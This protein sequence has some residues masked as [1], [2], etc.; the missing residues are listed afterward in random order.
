MD[1][2]SSACELSDSAPSR[3]S[4]IAESMIQLVH[5]YSWEQQVHDILGKPNHD[6]DRFPVVRSNLIVLF[7]PIYR[8][9][10]WVSEF[11]SV[12]VEDELLTNVDAFSRKFCGFFDSANDAF[13]SRDIHF[14]WVD[15]RHRLAC[16]EGK[17]ETNESNE[18]EL[19]IGFFKHGIKNLGWGF[20][21][22]DTIILGSA[23]VPFGLIYPRIGISTSPFNC[24][25]FC[26][27]IHGQLTLEISDVS[28]KPLE[29]KCCDLDLI[30]LKMLPRHRCENVLHTS[31]PTYS[32]SIG[33]DEGKTFGGHFSEGI[34]KIHVKAVQKYDECVK[35][36]GCLSDPILVRGFSGESWKDKKESSGDFFADR[37][38]E[39]L[40][41]ETGELMQRKCEPF[42]QI[43]LSFLFKEGYW[44]LV[45]L[46]NGNGDSC[47]G[48]L[49]PFTVH[50]G[51]LSTIDNEFYPQNMVDG[52]CGPKVGQFVTQ[53][54][55]EVCKHSDDMNASNEIID[56]QSGHFSSQESGAPGSGKQKMNKKH[57]HLHQPL[58]WSSF[59]KAAFEHNEMEIGEI[60]F[61]KEGKNTKKLKFLKCWM[62]QIKKS[63]CSIII[64][65]G[66]QLHQDIPKETQERLTVLHQ[67]SERPI[68]LSVSAQEDVLTGASR[69]QDEAA[70]DFCSETSE[71]FF[72]VLSG[73]IQEGIESEGVDLGA[74]AERLVSSSIHW[75]HQKFEMETSE[76]QNAEQKVDDPYGS[77]AVVELIK[78]LVKEP[79]DLAAKHKNNDPP[80][81][82]SDPRSTRLTSEKIVREYP[83]LF[84]TF[85][86][87]TLLLYHSNKLESIVCLLLL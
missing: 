69:I 14:T 17:G 52:F 24:S 53:R 63:S 62:K 27:V 86:Y 75:L 19:D 41:T 2:L 81:E 39:I 76:S 20:S 6:H 50:S 7:S 58:A 64:P 3:A 43:L 23:L 15:V 84:F 21:S 11:V 87:S 79:K 13:V 4:H 68:S 30:N 74:L 73:K 83:Y 37:V 59:C 31:E 16:G 55:R 18:P 65:D 49:K 77:K 9:L 45:S 33:C 72:S 54:S 70:L 71:A 35:I 29:W 12:E 8:S 26:K 48:I 47:M 66:S 61:A 82:S 40:A 46:S 32:Q 85:T 36:A 51:L 1:S 38:L 42:W 10:K 80:C 34:T 44:A 57:S 78:L 28:G 22:T 56:S 67:E 60:Y 5:D 25:N